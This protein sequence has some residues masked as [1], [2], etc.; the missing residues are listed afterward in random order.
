MKFYNL[1]EIPT[2]SDDRVFKAPS[3]G[4]FIWFLFF[5]SIGIILMMLAIGGRKEF[6]P[7]LPPVIFTCG[8]A[9]FFGLFSWM[10]FRQFQASLKPD[11]WLLRCNGGG[12]IIKYR[13]FYNW[14]FPE[15]DA[16]AV[17]L[18][19]SEIAWARI[20]KERR[21]SPDFGGTTRNVHRVLTFLELG[22]VNP[23]TAA[24]EAHLQAEQNI[25]TD[26]LAKTLDYPV[27][28]SPGGIIRLRWKMSG[29]YRIIPSSELALQYLSGSVKILAP[30]S[31]KVDLTR[32]RNRLPE[33]EDAKILALVRSGDH[34][35]AVQL[36][37]E[38][39]GSSLT[40]A[41]AF[42]EKLQAGKS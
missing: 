27:E 34:M 10:T 33:E 13:S 12:V 29:G 9:A 36:T 41:V 22:L 20:V 16:Q 5:S 26:G 23:D 24:L 39:Y 4:A 28:I 3:G 37:R 42:V 17:G 31:T 6:G 21:N 19:Y 40:D 14:R 38:V 18:S 2:S 30:D 7:K 35:G 25:K 15:S 8:G 32:D 11:N 1:R